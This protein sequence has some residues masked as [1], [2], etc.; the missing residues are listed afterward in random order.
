MLFYIVDELT[1]EILPGITAFP[2]FPDIG[3]QDRV[4]ASSWRQLCGSLE[5]SGA[6]LAVKTQ[7]LADLAGLFL[8]H[9]CVKAREW[10]GCKPGVLL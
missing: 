8:W 1:K 5:F 3:I 4:L 10:T 7:L 2:A 6:S 9:V